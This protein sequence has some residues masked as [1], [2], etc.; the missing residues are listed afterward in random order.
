MSIDKDKHD[1]LE[2][3]GI[4]ADLSQEFARQA[5]YFAEWGFAH[6][7]AEAEA[8][9][10]EEAKEVIWARLQLYYRKKHKGP[11]ENEVKA[12]IT[13]HRLY[14]RVI[15]EWNQ[16]K[17]YRDILRVAVESFKQRK[18]MLVQLGAD[19]RAELD[20]TDFS[21]KKKIERAN[22]VIKKTID[23]KTRRRK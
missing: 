4:G 13:K 21:M 16:A 6:A 22:K 14:R 7:V 10:T 5:S 11:K 1:I 3:I 9:R 19:K 23:K 8:R 15:L 18:D 2:E 12:W 20:V 17:Y